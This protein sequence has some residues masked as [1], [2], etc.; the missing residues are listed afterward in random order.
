MSIIL[1]VDDSQ[2]NRTLTEMILRNAGYSTCVACDGV[3]ALE[4]I[5]QKRPDLVLL[6]LHMPRMNGWELARYLKKDTALR[7]IPLIAL[8]GHGNFSEE[9]EFASANWAGYLS[10]PFDILELVETV[11]QCIRVQPYLGAVAVAS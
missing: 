4:V 1:I 11:Q 8:T 6:D 2:P 9:A 10:K 7:A 3:E 5:N